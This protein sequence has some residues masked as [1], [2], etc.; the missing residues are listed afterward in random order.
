MIVPPGHLQR[1]GGAATG[2]VR[3]ISQE[4][5]RSQTPNSRADQERE[6]KTN[7][8]NNSFIIADEEQSKE[9]I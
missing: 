9:E 7:K 6:D 1:V 3:G 4:R 2:D 8:P 5:I